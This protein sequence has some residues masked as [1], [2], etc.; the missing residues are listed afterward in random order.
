MRIIIPDRLATTGINSYTYP[1][2]A[3]YFNKFTD[4]GWYIV[5]VRDM[6]DE[7]GRNKIED[8]KQKIKY[9]VSSLERHKKIVIACTAGISRSNAIALAVLIEKFNHSFEGAV[10][11]LHGLK[12]NMIEPCHL[13]VLS[14]IYR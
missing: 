5:D 7:P 3:I 10:N 14:R 9:A 4:D 1:E 6:Y 2:L 11:Y 13:K 12:I 8:Y